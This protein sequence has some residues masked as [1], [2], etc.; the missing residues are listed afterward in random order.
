VQ[1]YYQQLRQSLPFVERLRSAEKRYGESAP[2]RGEKPLPAIRTIA[3][4]DV[5]FAYE[6]G[7]PALKGVS[8]DIR[9][10]EAIGVVGP[11]GAGKSTLAQLLLQ[12]RV[13]T[14]GRYLVNGEPSA[15]FAPEDWQR[16]VAYVPQAPHLIH[17]TVADNIAYY[18]DLPQEEIEL[19]ARLARI[20]GDIL[21]WREGY[22][23][24]V[25]PR[26]D[27]VSGG[28]AQRLCLARALAGRPE[29]LLL[30]EPTSALDPASER[31]I[32]ESLVGLKGST[33]LII[34]AHRISTL[35]LC[36]RVMV[37]VGGAVDAFESL[38][39]IGAENAYY[40]AAGGDV[41][42]EPRVPKSAA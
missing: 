26:A 19:A 37:I 5:S 32:Q 41:S 1:T 25:G 10:G 18:R 36:D 38:D 24:R 42:N 20:E 13:P 34:I 6:G 17:A 40:R 35:D 23:T 29:V 30:D 4:D 39:V 16:Q 12:L 8:F 21:S 7:V 3:F 9:A 28:Q 2:R 22:A 14:H 15:L 11:S 33:T 27:A 31:L